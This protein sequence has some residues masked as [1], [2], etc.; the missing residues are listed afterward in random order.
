MT[1]SP[2]ITHC[3]Q[4]AS[5]ALSWPSPKHFTCSVCGFLLYLNIAAAVA[6]IIECQGKILFG[7]RKH[8]PMRG[9]LDL[10]GGFV[11]QGESA[12]AALRRE[13]REELGLEITDLRYLFSFPNKYQYHGIEYDTL[14]MIFLAQ[15]DRFP[16][17]EAADDLEGVLWLEQSE[18]RFESIGFASLR[19]AVRQ[20]LEGKSEA[21][22]AV[23]TD[24]SIC[25]DAVKE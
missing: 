18:I 5:N 12:E 4:C 17:V 22:Q 9:M 11:D 19:Q 7:V 8:E 10:P 2:L 25:V 13:A 3:P 14:D 23:R 16:A 20:Y 15:F 1:G 21:V 6:A 24:V